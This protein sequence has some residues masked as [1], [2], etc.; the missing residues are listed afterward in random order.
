MVPFPGKR[1][2]PPASPCSRVA[3]GR[4]TRTSQPLPFP[5]AELPPPRRFRCWADVGYPL[6]MKPSL[7]LLSLGVHDL[8]KTLAF[9]RDGLGW[10]V[11]QAMDDVAFLP[12][13]TGLVLSLYTRK[14][15][16]RDLGI[17][18]AGDSYGGITLAHNVKT[19]EEV[20][21]I[22]EE[23]KR[24]GARIVKDAHTAEW[25]GTIGFF[26]DPDGHVWEVAHNPFWGLDAQGRVVLSA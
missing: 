24:A 5:R 21:V 1:K 15:L 6:R 17:A 4:R 7:S 19:K 13:S 3:V 9:Y 23:A 26:A 12:L 25:G 18:D 10:P 22:L 20:A 2:C 11:H 16:T 14:H 8:R